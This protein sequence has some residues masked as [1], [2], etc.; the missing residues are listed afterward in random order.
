MTTLV[1]RIASVAIRSLVHFTVL[2]WRGRT[3]HLTRFTMYQSLSRT[4]R[5][6]PEAAQGRVSVLSISGS[7]SLVRALGISDLNIT[8]ADFPAHDILR[9][10]AFPDNNF[11]VVVSDQVLEHVEGPPDRAIDQSFRVVK[12]NGL[13]IHT[14]CLINPIHYGPKDLWRFTPAALELL[15]RPHG[16]VLSSDGWGNAV[17]VS[18]IAFGLRMLPV[19]PRW[20]PIGMLA[21]RHQAD[22]P[23]VTWVVA[24]KHG[25]GK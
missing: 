7:D 18:F 25:P 20:H 1:M 17:A 2:P 4:L 14:T 23:I 9:L 16:T 24:R 3:V 8:S 13:V 6:E 19:P 15:C 22:W 11:D 5:G 12:P 10:D 21:R